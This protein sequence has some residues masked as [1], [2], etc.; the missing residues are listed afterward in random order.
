MFFEEYM[1]TP[2][3]TEFIEWYKNKSRPIIADAIT[4]ATNELSNVKGLIDNIHDK[5]QEIEHDI[6]NNTLLKNKEIQKLDKTLQKIM[7]KK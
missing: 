7:N 5:Q 6:L 4:N 3:M 1:L 2:T